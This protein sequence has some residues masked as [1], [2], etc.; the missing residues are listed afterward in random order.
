MVTWD[1]DSN[2]CGVVQPKQKRQRRSNT[3]AT[4]VTTTKSTSASSSSTATSSIIGSTSNSSSSSSSDATSSSSSATAAPVE[5]AA[6]VEWVQ[7]NQCQEWHELPTYIDV[8]SLP[9]RWFCTMVTW[10]SDSNTCGVVQPK[11]KWQRRSSSSSSS[12]MA[13][14]P[15]V[16]TGNNMIMDEASDP[17]DDDESNDQNDFFARTKVQSMT[18]GVQPEIP[19]FTSPSFIWTDDNYAIAISKEQ[20]RINERRRVA[21]SSWRSNPNTFSRTFS[22]FSIF[23]LFSFCFFS[24]FFIIFVLFYYSVCSPI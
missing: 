5:R 11:Q 4:T 1:S 20:K 7:C 9:D 6:P 8:A 24:H 17:D 2:T 19:L 14:S 23:S 22:F 18:L 21:G 10:D 16:S 13:L 15:S 3:P 12:T